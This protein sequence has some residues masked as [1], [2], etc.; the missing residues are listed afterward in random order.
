VPNC[1]SNWSGREPERNA[2]VV[3]GAVALGAA[4]FETAPFAQQSLRLPLPWR[5]PLSTDLAMCDDPDTEEEGFRHAN[6]EA[7]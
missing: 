1:I 3:L 4:A 5:S 2:R 6:Q 7:K